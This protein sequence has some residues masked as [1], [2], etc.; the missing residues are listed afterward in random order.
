MNNQNYF[1][2]RC[3]YVIL[4]GLG[5]PIMRYMS[6]NFDTLNNNAV[7]FISGGV[8][9][10][11]FCLLK[12]KNHLKKINIKTALLLFV[13][14]IFMTCNMF[15]FI[16]GIKNTSALSGSV[17]SI[18]AMP[19]GILV[20]SL[21]FIDERERAFNYKFI[22]GALIA[23][24]GSFLFI[25]NDHFLSSSSFNYIGFIFLTIAIC[26][27]S[28]QNVIVKI[29]AQYLPAIVISAST[30]TISGLMFLLL[31]IKTGVISE[32]SVT[33]KDLLI[34][35][36]LAGI[37]GMFT[38]MLMAFYIVKTQGVTIFNVTQLLIPVSTGIFGYFTLGEKVDVIQAI[39]AVIIIAGCVFATK[40]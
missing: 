34:L 4:M 29:V 8:L 32:L 18:L 2:V 5:F 38:G 16:N 30:A 7:R 9:F 11:I 31:A 26:I 17:F 27:Q 19:L 20:A 13:L 3:M 22:T 24:L 21:F 12:Y 10:C 35:L 6:L 36:V 14:S 28:I 25:F 1:L 39:G 37:Y 23:I 33:S 15:F 40:R